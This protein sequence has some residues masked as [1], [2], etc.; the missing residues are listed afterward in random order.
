MLERKYDQMLKI[1][2]RG[3]REWRDQSSQFNRY[4]ATPYVAL[5]KLFQAYKLKKDDEVVDFGCGRGRVPFYIHHHFQIPV[6][7]I[8]VNDQTFEEALNNK[9]TYRQQAQNIPAPIK[10]EYGF[11]E[12]YEVKETDNRFYFFNPFSVNIFKKVVG[13]IMGSLE[14]YDRSVDIILYY[15]L[16]EY[17]SF[18]KKNTP[19]YLMNKVRVPKA[20]DK[21]EKFLIYRYKHKD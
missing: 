16:Q 9:A 13:N 18:L 3:L 5:D 2:T 17:K 1:R 14:E 20:T 19:F 21:K 15:P 12:Q 11:A 7:G 4:E 6:T 10:L 8:E